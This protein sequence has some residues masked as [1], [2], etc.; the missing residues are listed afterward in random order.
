MLP[1]DNV[2]CL[3]LFL[4]YS[5]S[6]NGVPLK[7]GQ[8]EPSFKVIENGTITTFYPSAIVTIALTCTIF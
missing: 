1:N 2:Y 7:C 8:R 4:R 3:V 5:T 6:N